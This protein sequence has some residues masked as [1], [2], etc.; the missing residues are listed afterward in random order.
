MGEA[1]ALDAKGRPSEPVRWLV[2]RPLDAALACDH[3]LDDSREIVRD[4]RFDD[5]RRTSQVERLSCGS[6]IRI[7]P[8]S[9]QDDRGW[10]GQ[11]EQEGTVRPSALI[12]TKMEHEDIDAKPFEH[13]CGFL[14]ALDSFCPQSRLPQAKGINLAKVRVGRDEQEVA[15]QATTFAVYLR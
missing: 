11:V 6:P 8:A 9:Q 13:C 7:D 4:T 14:A 5:K 15:H 2:T 3:A 1:V 12:V 10:A